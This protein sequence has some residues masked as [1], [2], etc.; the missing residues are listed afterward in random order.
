MEQTYLIIGTVILGI[1]GAAIFVLAQPAQ[2]KSRSAG[3]GMKPRGERN[4]TRY[5][6]RSSPGQRDRPTL[7]PLLRAVWQTTGTHSKQPC[8]RFRSSTSLYHQL[9]RARA[10]CRLPRRVRRRRRACRPGCRSWAWAS[11]AW[12]RRARV[13]TA[14]LRRAAAA[15]AAAA[16]ERRRRRGCQSSTSGARRRRA[17]RP[18]CPSSASASSIWAPRGQAAT[19]PRPRAAAAAVAAAAAARR[20]S[21]RSRRRPRRSPRRAAAATS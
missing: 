14:R 6:A 5:A 12:G 4:S 21:R 8:R 11:S 18:G 3:G 2:T 15:A 16:A 9:T 19:A 10:A 17:C 1:I 13:A 7:T 20:A